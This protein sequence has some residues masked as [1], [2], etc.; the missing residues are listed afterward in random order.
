MGYYKDLKS[1][2]QDFTVIKDFGED[3]PFSPGHPGGEVQLDK[4]TFQL[5][6]PLP[7][8]LSCRVKAY[9][10]NKPILVHN[11]ARYVSEFYADGHQRGLDFEFQVQK[12]PDKFHPY[13]LLS[14]KYGLNFKLHDLSSILATGQ[15]VLCHFDRLDANG[16]SVRRSST[17]TN[18]P[19]LRIKDLMKGAMLYNKITA[20]D[21]EL[22]LHN[23]PGSQRSRRRLRPGSPRMDSCCHPRCGCQY[24]TVV[25]GQRS[26]CIGRAR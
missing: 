7:D 1:Q 8:T 15:K 23:T 4:L 13:Y 6:Q 9:D 25:C 18:L 20:R 19:M 5:S 3:E 24:R 11:T 16:F 14:D 22:L 2:T 10:G 21:F 17:D 12:Q 26:L